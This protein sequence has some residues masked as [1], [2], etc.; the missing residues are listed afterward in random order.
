MRSE[1]KGETGAAIRELLELRPNSANRIT[2]SGEESVP[3]DEICV[4][5]VLLVRPGERVAA[6][7]GVIE[8]ATSVDGGT[9]CGES[10]PV[11]KL[12]GAPVTG[13]TV[14]LTGAFKMRVERVGADSAL[15]QI[16]GWWAMPK[17]HEPPSNEWRTGVASVLFRLL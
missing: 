1:P 10:L 15:A 7:G 4:G 8:G 17:A 13:G 14:N 5:D 11:E 12:D 16:V 3:A 9:C 6:D 2:E